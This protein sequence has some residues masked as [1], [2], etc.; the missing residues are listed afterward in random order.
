YGGIPT[1]LEDIRLLLDQ[2]SEAHFQ[3]TL[4]EDP[5]IRVVISD[6][7]LQNPN[8]WQA[9]VPLVNYAAVFD[10][11]HKIDLRRSNTH[12]SVFHSEYIEMWKNWY[13]NIPTSEPIIV[14]E[15]A[16]DLDYM[17][18]FR[19]YGKSYLLLEEQRHQQFC[20]ERE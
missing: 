20:V 3:W 9:K 6:K 1:A 7:F 19:I 14:S 15:L 13:D 5:T 18:W 2:R 11:E 4:Y 17:S 12:W 10:D 16:C 8:I